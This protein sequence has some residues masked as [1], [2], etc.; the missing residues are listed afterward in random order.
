MIKIL[1]TTSKGSLS[2]NCQ[3]DTRYWWTSILIRVTSNYS[4]D[5]RIGT[6]A[7]S[8]RPSQV[9]FT[10]DDYPNSPFNGGFKVDEASH[11]HSVWLQYEKNHH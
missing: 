11:T 1:F 8:M 2:N 9:G 3:Y 7:L 4:D 10:V 5:F 6:Y